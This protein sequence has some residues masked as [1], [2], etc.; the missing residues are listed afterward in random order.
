M[1]RT[2]TA[3]LFQ[4]GSSQAVRLPADFRFEGQEVF[5]RRDEATGDVVLSKRPAAGSWTAFFTLLHEIDVPADFMAE[6]PM[7]APPR[8]P[9]V[10]DNQIKPQRKAGRKRL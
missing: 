2:R 1:E 8:R 10:F 6:R 7:N 9:G 3:K 5:I 4:N